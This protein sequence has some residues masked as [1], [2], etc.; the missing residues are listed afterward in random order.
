M[1]G[2]QQKKAARSGKRGR[3]IRKRTDGAPRLIEP[4]GPGNRKSECWAIGWTERTA[5]GRSRSRVAS[6]DEVEEARARD[7]LIVFKAER[8]RPPEQREITIR[9]I[10]EDFIDARREA[11]SFGSLQSALQ[12]II[13]EF[14][15]LRPDEVGASTLTK[16]EADRARAKK[17]RGARGGLTVEV[18]GTISRKTIKNELAMFKAACHWALGEGWEF[19]AP[20]FKKQKGVTRRRKR[21][22]SR[23]EAGRLFRAL[24]APET[25]RHLRTFAILAILTGQRSGSIRALKWEHVDFDEGMVWFTRARPDAPDNKRVQDQPMT[26][27]LDAALREAL[28]QAHLARARATERR[29][30]TRPVEYVIEFKQRSVGSL[31]TAWAALLARAKVEGV[32]I[33]DLRRTAATLTLNAGRSFAEVALYL[34]DSEQ[35]T[36]STYAHASPGLLLD[37]QQ[38]IATIIEEA[39]SEPEGP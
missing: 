25:P 6:T 38:T 29:H 36:K 12:P 7:A 33:H 31:K 5:D 3:S 32:W 17:R 34:N 30:P 8:A 24:R 1:S 27:E 15:P 22:L 18:E 39:A 2:V 11:H 14:G 9:K 35:I 4:G 21:T 23:A 13:E 26:P 28:A 20:P 16:Y 10:C 19:K 37:M